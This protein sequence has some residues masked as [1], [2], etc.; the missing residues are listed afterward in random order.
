MATE[1]KKTTVKKSPAK[2][3]AKSKTKTGAN[4]D[5]KTASDFTKKLNGLIELAH[6]SK[7]VI[8]RNIEYLTKEQPHT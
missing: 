6:K 2:S 5:E 1:T 7:D 8:E 4:V 3:T